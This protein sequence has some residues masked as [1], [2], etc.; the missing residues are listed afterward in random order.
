MNVLVVEDNPVNQLVAAEMLKRM[1]C[2]VEV[3]ENGQLAVERLRET[4]FDVVL[5]DLQMPVLDG[6]SAVRLIRTEEARDGRPRTRIVAVTAEATPGQH[7]ACLAM[8]FDDYLAKPF[9][10]SDL[11]ELVT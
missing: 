3:L 9:R 5:M 1:D 6:E 11:R 7:G 4:R 10:A 8:G 2:T